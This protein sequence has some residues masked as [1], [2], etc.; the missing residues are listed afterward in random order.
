[1]ARNP[2]YYLTVSFI[3]RSGESARTQ[4][5]VADLLA[6]D[7]VPASVTALLNAIVAIADGV[8]VNWQS[9]GV[10]K[11]GNT[12][13]ALIGQREERWLVVYEDTVTKAVYTNEIPCRKSSVVPPLETDRVDL[14]QG[15]WPAFVSA[16]EGVVTSPDGNPVNVLRVQLTGRNL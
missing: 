9:S 7:P 6:V 12:S 5:S 15:P 3:D 11:Q 1:M 8:I 4:L 16:F 13:A 2:N 14:T 10:W